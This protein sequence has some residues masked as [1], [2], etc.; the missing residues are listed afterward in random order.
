[1]KQINFIQTTPEELNY[2]FKRIL[3]NHFEEFKKYFQPK[4]P[5]EYLTRKETAELLKVDLSTLYSWNKK[6][7]LRPVGIGKRVYYRRQDIENAMIE[8]NAS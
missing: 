5:I 7:I 1:M 4:E 2:Q 3:H 8:L 6:G